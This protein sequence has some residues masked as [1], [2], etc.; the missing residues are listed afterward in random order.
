[1]TFDSGG[2]A[3]NLWAGGA[4]HTPS[5]PS[6]PS[7]RLPPA[8]R[9]RGRDRGA[10]RRRDRDENKSH[11]WIP[12]LSASAIFRRDSLRG[13]RSR[14]P[15]PRR[16]PAETCAPRRPTWRS[17]I[18]DL[19]ICRSTAQRGPDDR[20][21]ASIAASRRIL[22]ELVRLHCKVRA[23]SIRLSRTDRS[24]HG[25]RPTAGES[26]NRRT[27]ERDSPS[28]SRSPSAF[29]SYSV[30]RYAAKLCVIHTLFTLLLHIHIKI[31]FGICITRI[32]DSKSATRR[33]FLP[34]PLSRRDSPVDLVAFARPQHAP[35][36]KCPRAPLSLFGD[37][38][39]EL[40]RT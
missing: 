31:L 18:A 11:V 5:R 30:C 27:S 26:A 15:S 32:S 21:E 19:P 16:S 23:R 10:D 2:R 33:P 35:L 20:R 4:P 17:K 7:T 9:P 29:P 28:P 6:H 1:M 13:S 14:P 22:D 40:P 37:S 36:D 38:D 8:P 39:D 12:L 3:A 24:I 25:R 34:P